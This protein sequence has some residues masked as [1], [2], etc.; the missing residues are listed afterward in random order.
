MLTVKLDNQH[1]RSDTRLREGRHRQLARD[2]DGSAECF[3]YGL[4]SLAVPPTLPFPGLRGSRRAR[5]A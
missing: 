4:G 3:L 2:L 5:T 1:L